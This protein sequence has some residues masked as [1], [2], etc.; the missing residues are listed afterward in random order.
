MTNLLSS[1][2]SAPS[3]LKF[4]T[5]TENITGLDASIATPVADW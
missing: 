3:A 4:S 1:Q 2:C 5:Q